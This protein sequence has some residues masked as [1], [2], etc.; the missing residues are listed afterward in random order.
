MI[1]GETEPE[2]HHI[3]ERLPEND[4]WQRQIPKKG[5]IKTVLPPLVW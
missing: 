5:K 2:K 4:A 1:S 3:S